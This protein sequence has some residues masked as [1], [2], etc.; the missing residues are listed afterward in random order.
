ML[1]Y[2][3]QINIKD[4]SLNFGHKILFDNLNFCLQNGDKIIIVGDNSSGKST[5]IN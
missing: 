3:A 2:S 4:L 5:L 1:S